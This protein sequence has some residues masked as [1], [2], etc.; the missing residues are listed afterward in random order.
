M[1]FKQLPGP[2]F[3]LACV[4]PLQ[5]LQGNKF[6]FNDGSMEAS[7]EYTWEITNEGGW[8]GGLLFLVYE[9]DNKNNRKA[10]RVLPTT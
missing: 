7:P 1:S 9:G 3:L 5:D 10:K 8:G 2:I 6:V 4:P